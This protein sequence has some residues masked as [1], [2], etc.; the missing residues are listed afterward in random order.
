MA[1]ISSAKMVMVPPGLSGFV[2]GSL[3]R[4]P[5]QPTVQAWNRPPSRSGCG[6]RVRWR[7]WD[8]LSQRPNR[9]IATKTAAAS[10]RIRDAGATLAV[11]GLVDW[12]AYEVA[13]WTQDA[14]LC[15]DAPLCV[16]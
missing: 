16:N 9:D 8:E 13:L 15:H 5:G 6:A 1:A 3:L 4:R 7:L 2:D 11:D 10:D 12:D 14:D